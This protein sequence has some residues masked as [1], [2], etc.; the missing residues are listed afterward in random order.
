[1]RPIALVLAAIALAGCGQAASGGS[2]E[3]EEQRVADAVDGFAEAAQDRDERRICRAVLA[4]ALATG[5]GDCER[6]IEGVIDAADT[7][8][9]AVEDVA[10]QG[11]DRAR[12][13]VGTG[14][15]EDPDRVI[16]LVRTG[17]EWRIADLGTR[18]ASA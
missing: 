4:P 9:L 6:E 14:R 8:E 15:E 17:G 3:G 5:L 11:A 18:T 1:M 13:R 16:T 10:L 2:F 12:A 7:L